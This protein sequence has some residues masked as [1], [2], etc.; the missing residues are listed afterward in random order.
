MQPLSQSDALMVG[1]HPYTTPT[2]EEYPLAWATVLDATEHGMS[3]SERD[4]L[5]MICKDDARLKLDGNQPQR[6]AVS[7][8]RAGGVCRVQRKKRDFQRH[9][10]HHSSDIHAVLM[11]IC[12]PKP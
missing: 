6:T 10:V 5:A 9:R 11:N 3:S 1:L 8:V 12:H 7:A 2:Q 4:V